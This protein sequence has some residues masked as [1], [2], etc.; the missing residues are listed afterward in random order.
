MAEK[1]ELRIMVVDDD[2][3]NLRI[4]EKI[5]KMHGITPY[6]VSSGKAAVKCFIHLKPFDYIFMD[7]LM[8]EMDGVDTMLEI[9]RLEGGEDTKIIAMS[10]VSENDTGE[11][12]L[13]AGFD[14]FISKPIEKERMMGVLE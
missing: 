5:L 13:E 14:G 1:K 8:P 4:A 2:I 7:H 10:A 6:I 3:S 9:R 12:F 11:G